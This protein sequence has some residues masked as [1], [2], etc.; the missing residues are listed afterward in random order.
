MEGMLSV[1]SYGLGTVIGLIALAALAILIIHDVTQKKHTVLRNFP[2]IGRLRFFFEN[3]GEYF[4]QYFFAGDRDEMPFNRAT[5]GWI[6]RSAKNEGGL[7]GFGSTNDLRE[8]GSI[9][10]VNHP[11][12]VLEEDRLPTPSIMIGDGYC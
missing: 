11:F 2:V 3:L 10:F 1:V 9:I 8:P 5:R 7:I 6:Y 4:R 12:P